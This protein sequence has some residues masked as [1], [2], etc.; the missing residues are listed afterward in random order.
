MPRLSPRDV[1]QIL[2]MLEDEINY[3][4]KLGK[5]EKMKMR[6]RVRKQFNWLA[7]LSSPTAERIFHGLEERLSDMFSLYPYGFNDRLKRL[8]EEKSA[9]ARSM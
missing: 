5:I 2:Q 3:T 8:L 9:P 7:G 1:R 6:V 4:P